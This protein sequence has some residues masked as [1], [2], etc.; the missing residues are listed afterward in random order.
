MTRSIIPIKEFQTSGTLKEEQN[1]CLFKT[2]INNI[3]KITRA[4]PL[5]KNEFLCFGSM[6]ILS[7]FNNPFT[8]II[9]L[10]KQSLRSSSFATLTKT[11]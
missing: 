8:K 7:R 3:P 9:N 2:T 6:V 11:M 4:N 10:P 5:P 1:F